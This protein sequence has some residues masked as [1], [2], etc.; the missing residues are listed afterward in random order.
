MTETTRRR[1]RLFGLP[2]SSEAYALRDYLQRSVVAFDWIEIS[3]EAECN[4][5]LGD[6]SASPTR[7]SFRAPEFWPLQREP[8]YLETSVPGSCAAGDVRHRAVNRVAVGEAQW[9]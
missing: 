1:V 7:N 5:H 6:G 3:S 8:Y 4:T 9:R 2:Q